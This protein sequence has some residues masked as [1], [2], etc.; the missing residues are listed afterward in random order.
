M[1]KVNVLN[2][3]E[4]IHLKMVKMVS[5]CTFST[6]KNLESVSCSV[7]SNSLWSHGLQPARLLYPWNFLSNNTR[8]GSHSFPQEIFPTQGL[9][10]DLLHW[11]EDSSPSEP[12]EKPKLN[13]CQNHATTW[14]I[15]KS[16]CWANTALHKRKPTVWFHLYEFKSIIYVTNP[17]WKPGQ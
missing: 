10:L 15:S 8:V 16:P 3:T 13:I 1:H 4:I 12:P 9:N 11:Q 5:L 17:W 14:R 7:V 2:A 6:I